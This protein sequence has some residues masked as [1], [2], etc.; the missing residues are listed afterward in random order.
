MCLPPFESLGL[1]KQDLI[2]ENS[3]QDG[4]LDIL[5]LHSL[6]WTYE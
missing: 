1:F 2:L 3:N 4:I 6:A 5:L